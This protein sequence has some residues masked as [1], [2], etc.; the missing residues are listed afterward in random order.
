MNRRAWAGVT[1]MEV[2]SWSGFFVP[3]H[4]PSDIIAKIHTDTVAAVTEPA[5]RERLEQSGA[6]VIGSTPD[7]LASFLRGEMEK[8]GTIIKEANIKVP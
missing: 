2:S 3:A 4:T 7:E 5:L 8:W 6:E 1:G